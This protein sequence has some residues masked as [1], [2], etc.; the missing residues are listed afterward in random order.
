MV[1]TSPSAVTVNAL[2]GRK[3]GYQKAV[4]VGRPSR[5]SVQGTPAGVFGRA[6]LVVTDERSLCPERL[7]VRAPLHDPTQST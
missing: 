4:T 7:A 1:H 2:A 3:P 6:V 5:A